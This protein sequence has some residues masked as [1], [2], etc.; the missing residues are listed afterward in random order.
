MLHEDAFDHLEQEFKN[1]EGVTR[2][3]TP[4]RIGGFVLIVVGVIAAAVWWVVN[5]PSY[6]PRKSYITTTDS[7]IEVVE[8]RGNLS[9]PPTRFVWESVTGRLQYVVRVY[10]K[11]EHTPIV[12]RMVTT[13]FV[14]LTP[15]E[16]ARIPRGKTFVWTVAAQAKDGSTM[17][18]GQQTFKV[19]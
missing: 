19:R 9:G 11:G 16:Q 8:P 14:E 18:A 3:G 10:V 12:E 13:P 2:F 17:A 6:T 5:P 15:G 4:L 1:L 7:P